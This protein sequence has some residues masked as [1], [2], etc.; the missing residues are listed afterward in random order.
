V[1]GYFKSKVIGQP[2]LFGALR[3]TVIGALAAGTAFFVARLIG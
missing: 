3:I 1:F 2:P